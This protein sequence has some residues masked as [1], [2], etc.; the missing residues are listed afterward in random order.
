MRTSPARPD[1][2]RI[3]SVMRGE[4]QNQAAHLPL[5]PAVR[6]QIA[7]GAEERPPCH[8][9]RLEELDQGRRVGRALD[10]GDAL[11]RQLR[12]GEIAKGGADEPISPVSRLAQDDLNARQQP[13]RQ[14]GRID[15]A[16]IGRRRLGARRRRKTAPVGVERLQ[17]AHLRLVCDLTL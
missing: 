6:A 14:V 13:R 3:D 5:R 1:H 15:R 9:H 2:H 17:V 10:L 4:R 16:P 11:A 12:P 7:H 8:A